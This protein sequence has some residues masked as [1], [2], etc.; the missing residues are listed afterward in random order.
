[1][2]TQNPADPSFGYRDWKFASHMI[3]AALSPRGA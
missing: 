3:D 1:M 2:L